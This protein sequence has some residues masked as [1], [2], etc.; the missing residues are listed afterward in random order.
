MRQTIQNLRIAQRFLDAQ[1]D[2]KAT[3]MSFNEPDCTIRYEGFGLAKSKLRDLIIDCSVIESFSVPSVPEPLERDRFLLTFFRTELPLEKLM[4]K[5][6]INT[7]L[8]SSYGKDTISVTRD[9]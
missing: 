9:L 3:S 5:L 4:E 2:G 1:L 8:Y 7:I 6:Q